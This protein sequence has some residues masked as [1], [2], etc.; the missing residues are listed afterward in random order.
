MQTYDI[1]EALAAFL[2]KP[3]SVDVDM[4]KIQL[5]DVSQFQAQQAETL[6]PVYRDYPDD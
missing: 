4:N 6:K 2:G 1:E 5:I 3:A